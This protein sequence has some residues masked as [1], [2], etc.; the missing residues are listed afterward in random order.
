MFYD[1]G[2]DPDVEGDNLFPRQLLTPSQGFK[3]TCFGK[4]ANFSATDACALFKKSTKKELHP[5]NEGGGG[6]GFLNNIEKCNIGLSRLP[7]TLVCK[8]DD[9]WGFI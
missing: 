5:K 2:A 7:F 8:H 6:K 9:G 1:S 4:E 3:S